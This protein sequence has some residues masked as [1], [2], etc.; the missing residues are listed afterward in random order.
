MERVKTPTPWPSI[1]VKEGEWAGW[2]KFTADPFEEHSGPFYHRRGG[3][4]S[5][6]CA[7]RVSDKQLNGGGFIHGGALMTFADFCLFA[8]AQDELHEAPAV[9]VTLTASSLPLSPRAA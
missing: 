9:T 8:I 4:G 1:V 5:I 3:E 2:T 7:M 6:F